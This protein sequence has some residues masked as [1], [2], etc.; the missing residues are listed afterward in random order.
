MVWTVPDV[1]A[2][3]GSHG[4]ISVR[5]G[6]DS[7]GFQHQLR[8]AAITAS[9]TVAAATTAP[10]TVTVAT[11]AAVTVAATTAVPVTAPAVAAADIRP[12]PLE[13]GPVLRHAGS[14]ARSR[15]GGATSLV[16]S[17]KRP[18]PQP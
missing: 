6:A 15:T 13:D 1:I 11:A 12:Y 10:V 2:G 16:A 4:G 18:G 5:R 3:V 14:S 17:K 9:V 7:A 8:P